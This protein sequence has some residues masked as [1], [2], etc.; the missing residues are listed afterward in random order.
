M[1]SNIIAMLFK[2]V[3]VN[4]GERK[5][6]GLPLHTVVGAMKVAALQGNIKVADESFGAV[7]RLA[8]N[9]DGSLRLKKNGETIM[10]VNKEIRDGGKVLMTNIVASVDEQ[11]TVFSKEHK[12]QWT[13]LGERAYA[14]AVPLFADDK[15]LVDDTIAQMKAAAAEAELAAA[16]AKEEADKVAAMKAELEALRAEKAAAAA[17]AEPPVDSTPE[18]GAEVKS[19]GRKK[20]LA[21]VA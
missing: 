6:S 4:R 12:E 7:E 16:I 19:R 14:A 2:P 5:L 3:S 8:R 9:K 1:E 17:A 20:E 13:Q 10:E 15:K 21:A 18:Q 11:V